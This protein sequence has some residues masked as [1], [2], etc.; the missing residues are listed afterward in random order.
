MEVQK[1]SLSVVFVGNGVL[2]DVAADFSEYG[3]SSENEKFFS[4]RAPLGASEPCSFPEHIRIERCKVECI[5]F[6][7]RVRTF[8]V[9]DD[10]PREQ[11]AFSVRTDAVEVCRQLSG[12]QPLPHSAGNGQ[13]VQ[14]ASV[15]PVGLAVRHVL[16]PFDAFCVRLSFFFYR[17]DDEASVRTP[18]MAAQVLDI[19]EDGKRSSGF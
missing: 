8:G 18:D 12:G 7:F 16:E 15:P 9:I 1:V 10:R 17:I 19:F 14:V 6:C 3:G 13:L 5:E 4:A 11:E 2:R